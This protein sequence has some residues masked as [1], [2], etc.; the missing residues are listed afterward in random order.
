LTIKCTHTRTHGRTDA[1]R[2]KYVTFKWK[3]L[4]VATN[5]HRHIFID[6]V[7]HYMWR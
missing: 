2:F 5:D 3:K 7:S 6:D 4:G 1:L